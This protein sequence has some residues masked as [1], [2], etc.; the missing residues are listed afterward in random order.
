M[1]STPPKFL[2]LDTDIIIQCHRLEIW[3]PLKSRCR[4]AVPSVIVSEAQFFKSRRGRGHPINLQAQV[5]SEE[6]ECLEAT[7]DELSNG[8][9][10][11]VPAFCDGLHDG[12]KEALGLLL[13]GRCSGHAFCTG[14]ING[15]VAASMLGLSSQ[16]LSLESVV[17]RLGLKSSC[18]STIP[19]HMT[20]DA[21]E[22]HVEQGRQNRL[23]G[24]YFRS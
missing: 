13:G 9:C 19:R 11:F 21:L 1:P 16:L 4:V 17:S 6:I 20:D 5:E 22:Y 8:T 12:E 7:I 15:I 18:K 2:L 24:M 14:D 3:T 23:T 10:Q